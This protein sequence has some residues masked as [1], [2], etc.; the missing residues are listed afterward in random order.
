VNLDNPIM[1]SLVGL[2]PQE[3]M[4]SLKPFA[5]AVQIHG[6]GLIKRQ[7]PESGA[8]ISQNIRVT[9]FLEE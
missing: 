5:P 8:M 4:H 2:T 9:L 1:P 7:V 6:F 3:A